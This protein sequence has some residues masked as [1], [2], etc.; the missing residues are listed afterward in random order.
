MIAGG[1]RLIASSLLVRGTL[2]M[3]RVTPNLLFLLAFAAAALPLYSQSVPNRNSQAN[4]IVAASLAAMGGSQAFAHVRDV[5]V[6]GSMKPADPAAAPGAFTW[7]T[8]GHEFRVEINQAGANTVF[9]SNHGSGVIQAQRRRARLPVHFQ[10]A[11]APFYLPGLVLARELADTHWVPSFVGAETL[12]GI[13]VL[14]LRLN[15]RTSKVPAGRLQQDWYFDAASHL[16]LRVEFQLPGAAGWERDSLEFSSY[17]LV[18]G[19]QMPMELAFYQ[20]E[21]LS[22]HDVVS[23]VQ[24]N[25]NPSPALFEL[26]WADKGGAQ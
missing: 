18:S 7:I 4:Q 12:A 6:Q 16:P 2:T 5:T 10:A 21:T 23:R 20:N 24:I 26:P 15:N 17:A 8:S 14:H 3:K 9:T 25:A 22:V 13:P 19:M 11:N 1:G